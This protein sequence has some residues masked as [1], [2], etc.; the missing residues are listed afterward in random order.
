MKKKLFFL[1]LVLAAVLLAC[2]FLFLRSDKKEVAA[3]VPSNANMVFFFD[4]K[5]LFETTDL[6]ALFNEYH[7]EWEK[8]GLDL[9]QPAYG[10]L[11][12]QKTFGFVLPLNGKGLDTGNEWLKKYA[13]GKKRGLLW[14]SSD[15]WTL[16]SDK[17]RCLL[18]L[19][20]D[21]R[22]RNMM[23]DLMQKKE[24]DCPKIDSL[25]T[26]FLYFPVR[27]MV[28]AK[29]LLSLFDIHLPNVDLSTTFLHGN[30]A[31]NG[32]SYTSII[33]LE[34]E[35]EK[36][37]EYLKNADEFLK[38]V[39]GQFNDI[40]P[41]HPLVR[42]TF[43]VDG[44]KLLQAL[45]SIP[46][47]R[48]ALIGLNFCADVD[49]MIKSIDGDVSLSLL[50]Y[51]QNN[52]IPFMLTAHVSNTDYMKNAQSWS[53]KT[54]GVQVGTKDDVF[55][56]TSDAEA[57]LHLFDGLDEYTKESESKLYVTINLQK[58]RDVLL[59]VSPVMLRPF[60]ESLEEVK[61]EF[62]TTQHCLIDL[63]TNKNLL[64]LVVK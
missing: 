27:F 4:T 12:N 53:L 37:K 36:V 6:S 15:S 58:L 31:Q 14:A 51:P 8:A 17:D 42:T 32:K 39:K 16:C 50:E 60:V 30:I 23:Y 18:M 56:A 45:R 41:Q 22:Q 44:G 7:E 10:F 49:Q 40:G 34:T 55:F 1:C 57:A 29:T 9:T 24:T 5:T 26:G 13:E 47:I 61:L 25:K 19:S 54:F 63:K 35:N 11:S 52:N 28:E 33:T 64:D 21:S 20:G 43:S 48:A 46:K 38:P 3:V 2:A 59:T 62:P